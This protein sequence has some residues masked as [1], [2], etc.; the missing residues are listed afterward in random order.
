MFKSKLEFE[1][2][3]NKSAFLITVSAD[4]DKRFTCARVTG[5]RKEMDTEKYQP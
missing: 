4:H 1:E 3:G 5:E 2:R